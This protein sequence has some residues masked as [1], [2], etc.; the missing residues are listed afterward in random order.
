MKILLLWTQL[1]DHERDLL[2]QF[3]NW[4]AQMCLFLNLG[5]QA[6]SLFGEEEKTTWE[7]AIDKFNNYM[8]DLNTRTD[9]MMEGIMSSQI[10][11]ELE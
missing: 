1:L 3:W 2:E 11:R 6:R 10:S 8:T 4:Q 9:E 5:C 7:V